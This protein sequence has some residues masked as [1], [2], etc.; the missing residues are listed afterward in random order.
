MCVWVCVTGGIWGS[1][2]E[3]LKNIPAIAIACLCQSH[4]SRS[5]AITNVPSFFY[6]SSNSNQKKKKKKWGTTQPSYFSHICLYNSIP[7]Q[8]LG[9]GDGGGYLPHCGTLNFQ[10]HP[11]KRPGSFEITTHYMLFQ[12]RPTTHFE[13][14]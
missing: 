6:P 3:K 4:Q 7:C 11:W 9:Q 2:Q 14:Q 1:N 12:S 10:L 8:V 5:A 13:W